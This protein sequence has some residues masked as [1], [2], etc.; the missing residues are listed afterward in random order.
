MIVFS[1][2]SWNRNPP[3]GYAVAR[4]KFDISTGM[5]TGDDYELIHDF[6]ETRSVRPVDGIFLKDGTLLYTSDSSNELIAIRHSPYGTIPSRSIAVAW[7]FEGIN[8]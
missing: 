5:P 2:G 8:G 6:L 7:T 4:V 3:S 1:H